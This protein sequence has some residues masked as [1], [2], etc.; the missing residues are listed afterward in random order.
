MYLQFILPY[1]VQYYIYM[2]WFLYK[3]RV[4]MRYAKNAVNILASK[5]SLHVMF[6]FR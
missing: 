3:M 5:Y 2:Y 1:N 4:G 6:F